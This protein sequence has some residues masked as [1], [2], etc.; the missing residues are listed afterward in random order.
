VQLEEGSGLSRSALVT[1]AAIVDLLRIMA[2]HRES[3]VF[4]ECLPVAGVDGTLRHRLTGAGTQ[5]RVQAKTG[6]LRH[7]TALSGYV[8][9]SS[10]R[11]LVFS[12]M[13]NQFAGPPAEARE[14]VDALVT[15]LASMP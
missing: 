14:A 12:V 7:V 10:G 9:T 11:A 2:V 4:R 3:A 5:G 15:I 6:T 8:E 13:L 1:P